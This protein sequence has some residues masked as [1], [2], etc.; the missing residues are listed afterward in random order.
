MQAG[1]PE[2]AILRYTTDG[3]TPTAK[4]KVFPRRG[5]T[6]GKDHRPAAQAFREGVVSSGNRQRHLF[7][8]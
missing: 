4:S 1:A 3:D 7:R 5:L 6:L 8:G 2:G